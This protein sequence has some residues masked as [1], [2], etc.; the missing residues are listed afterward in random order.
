VKA[1][2]MQPIIAECRAEL[3]RRGWSAGEM[4]VRR[5]DGPV[6]VVHA[7]DGERRVIAKA[8]GQSEAWCEALRLVQDAASND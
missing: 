7:E 8:T 1:N 5:A 6:W 2:L 4:L 3:Q